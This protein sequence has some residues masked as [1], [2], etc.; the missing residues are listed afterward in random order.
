MN[1]INLANRKIFTV[2]VEDV[3]DSRGCACSPNT[4]AKVA[5]IL[6][7]STSDIV[8][9]KEG[10]RVRVESEFSKN[11]SDLTITLS[12]GELFLP[13]NYTEATIPESINYIKEVV[14]A[15]DG[16]IAEIST[17]LDIPYNRLVEGYVDRYSKAY[18]LLIKSISEDILM[19]VNLI[20]HVSK[21]KKHESKFS[22]ML[23]EE[24]EIQSAMKILKEFVA[25]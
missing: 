16:N 24:N 12:D 20:E 5:S 17:L 2:L 19:A 18:E 4:I 23:R 10:D 15:C 14:E 21:I 7:S 6:D 3:L 9:C 22:R 8:V 25:K 11:L 1:K 13:E